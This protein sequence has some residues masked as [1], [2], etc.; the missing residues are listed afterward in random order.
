MLKRLLL[1]L[2]VIVGVSG[3]Y[4]EE[5]RAQV[6]AAFGCVVQIAPNGL[7]REIC[8]AHYFVAPSGAVIVYDNFYR[9]WH[10]PG[11][12]YRGRAI[13]RGY[14]PG[15]LRRYGSY[16]RPRGFYG[17][18]PGYTRGYYGGGRGGYTGHVG[19]RGRR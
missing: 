1:S 16:Y 7:E 3:C 17:G 6:P 2:L 10:G 5:A 9:V 12:W 14:Y 4:I 18:F 8:N 19:G 11:Y 15:Y 13:V